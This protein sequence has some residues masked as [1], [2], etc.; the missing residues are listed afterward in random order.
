MFR[1][2][3]LT[4]GDLFDENGLVLAMRCVF[5][6]LFIFVRYTPTTSFTLG[7]Y[8]PNPWRPIEMLPG[9]L[10]YRT[11][12]LYFGLP[13]EE[14]KRSRQRQ[15]YLSFYAPKPWRPIEMLPGQSY[16]I[17]LYLQ[18]KVLNQ[19]AELRSASSYRTSLITHL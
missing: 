19:S 3:W 12:I 16:R 10:Y 6:F 15:S 8:A 14:A 1:H 11:I 5:A 4:G 9:L 7:F 2:V 18:R 13:A 17:W